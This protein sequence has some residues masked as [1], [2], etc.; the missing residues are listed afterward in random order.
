[1]RDYLQKLN[2]W[3]NTQTLAEVAGA[4]S[5]KLNQQMNFYSSREWRTSGYASFFNFF[6]LSSATYHCQRT[7]QKIQSNNTVL[8]KNIRFFWSN[9]NPTW[10]YKFKV[11]YGIK[12]AV[13]THLKYFEYY[14]KKSLTLLWMRVYYNIT[15]VLRTMCDFKQNAF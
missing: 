13:F 7:I 4:V 15:Y 8:S 12:N 2:W 3:K 6:K 9:L 5:L 14:L 1:M 10:Q 11:G